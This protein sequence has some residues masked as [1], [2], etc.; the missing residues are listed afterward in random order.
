MSI[1]IARD[2]V[3]EP[4]YAVV[5]Y[6]NSP[7]WKSR[8]KHTERALKH[9]HDS[10]ATI[11]FVE[12]A[13]NRRE[14]EFENIGIDGVSTNCN[15][16]LGQDSRFK[17]KHIKLR[18]MSELWLKEN[19]INAGVMHLPYDWEQVCWLDSD[20]HF[21]RPNWVGEAIH[22]LQHTLQGGCA[23]LQ[24][25]S[26]ARDLGPNYEMLA[27]DYPKADGLGFVHAWRQGLLKKAK[28]SK[29]MCPTGT[30]CTYTVRPSFVCLVIPSSLLQ[31]P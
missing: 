27:E 23:F 28:L 2:V 30:K 20:V 12:L 16:I 7:R 11:V 13:Y 6:Q 19:M 17:H 22:K 26:H 10:G 14:F 29:C 24:M 8:V 18:T 9:Y 31:Y 4:L 1:L 25:F 21:L 15:S 3:R 5:P